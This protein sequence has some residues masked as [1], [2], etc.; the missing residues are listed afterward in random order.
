MYELALIISGFFL[1]V[2]GVFGAIYWLGSGEP[3]VPP[4]HRRPPRYRITPL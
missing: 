1:G 3:R 2:F 4:H